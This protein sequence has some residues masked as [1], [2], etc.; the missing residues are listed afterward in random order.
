MKTYNFTFTLSENSSNANQ[1]LKYISDNVF[2][3][4]NR[5]LYYVF[6]MNVISCSE[7]KLV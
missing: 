1:I 5:Y 3:K 4:F 2:K 7:C 6:C